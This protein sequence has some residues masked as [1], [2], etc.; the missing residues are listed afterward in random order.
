[1]DMSKQIIMGRRRVL[2][3]A[4]ISTF[5]LMSCSAQPVR[6]EPIV[7]DTTGV[8][9]IRDLIR[10]IK[11]A[12]GNLL[13]QS[14]SDDYILVAMAKSFIENARDAAERYGVQIPSW[15]IERLPNRKVAWD[16][17][18][19]VVFITILGV[20]F[21]LPQLLFFTV[22]LGSILLMTNF[23]ADELRKLS[24]KAT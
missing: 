22:L 12:G 4:I 17:T 18:E 3:M 14:N 8:K 2:A 13:P 7:V 5:A 21:V 11:A 9:D 24:A 1:M 6:P 10:A 16:K 20:V 23:I 19:A 15:I